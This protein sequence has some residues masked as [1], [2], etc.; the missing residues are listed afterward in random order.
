M[1]GCCGKLGRNNERV[2]IKLHLIIF[3]ETIEVYLKIVTIEIIFEVGMGVSIKYTK[4]YS[5]TS[6]ENIETII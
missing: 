4:Q 2:V 5:L 1:K 6:V 3:F